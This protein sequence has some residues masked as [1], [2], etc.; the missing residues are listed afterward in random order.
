MSTNKLISVNRFAYP[1]M[2]IIP[3]IT[4]KMTTKMASPKEN[5]IRNY[6]FNTSAAK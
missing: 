4:S 2:S 1:T 5:D 6:I 3:K